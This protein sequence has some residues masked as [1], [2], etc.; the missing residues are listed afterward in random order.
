MVSDIFG[1]TRLA[2][3]DAEEVVLSIKVTSVIDQDLV[4][5]NTEPPSLH[6]GKFHRDK[7]QRGKDSHQ[8]KVAVG[9]L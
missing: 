9:W 4:A 2:I 3:E 5:T 7:G 6:L 1:P 8:R